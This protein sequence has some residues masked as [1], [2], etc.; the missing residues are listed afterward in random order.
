MKTEQLKA[1]S[2]ESLRR[3]LRATNECRAGI[4]SDVE[5][6]PKGFERSHRVGD[7]SVGFVYLSA[8]L[9][10][11]GISIMFVQL[12]NG[13]KSSEKSNNRRAVKKAVGNQ[14]KKPTD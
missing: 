6:D 3:A 11:N 2:V 8:P 12:N 1:V 10:Q 13:Y 7:G 5:A 4:T 14:S 9:L